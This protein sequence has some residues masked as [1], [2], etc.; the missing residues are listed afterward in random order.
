MDKQVTIER[1]VRKVKEYAAGRTKDVKRG[2]ETPRLAA[3]LVQKYG[4]GLCDATVEIFEDFRAADPISAAVDAETAK[5]DPLWREHNEE[6]WA[7]RPADVLA[8]PRL[9]R[10]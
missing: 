10:E 4:R 5:I 3:L 1:L 2:A 7:G 6:R 8:S 9:E